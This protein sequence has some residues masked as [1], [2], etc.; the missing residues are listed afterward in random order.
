MLKR[1]S[2]LT[3]PLSSL[4]NYI[5]SIGRNHSN[6]VVVMSFLIGATYL[7]VMVALDR[8]SLQ[9]DISSLTSSQ[10]IRFQQ[11]AN[12]TRALMRASTDPNLPEYIIAPMVD[13][14]REAVT[15][16]RT[17]SEQL[18][19]LH[20][21]IGQNLLEKLTPRDGTSELLRV[22][23]NRR[24]EDFLRRAGRVT[25]AK[26]EERRQR[27]SFWGPIDFAVSSEGTLTRQFSDLIH[28]T[29]DRSN[30][31]IDNAKMIST[32]LLALIAATLA[33]A[34]AFLFSPLLKKLRNEHRRTVD[35]ENQLKQL[36]HTDALTGIHNRSAFSDT[37][38]NLFSELRRNGTGFSVLLLDLDRFKSINDGFGHP[39]GDAVL[40]HVA[41]ALQR[42]F[43]S[44]DFVARLGG[45]EFAVLLPGIYDEATLAGIANRAVE[46]IAADFLFEGRTL[47]VSA[48]IGGAVVPN[49]ATDEP[50]LMRV[51]DLALYTA[52]SGRNT[53]I[54]FD[55]AALARRLEENQLSLALIVA[56]DRNEFIVHYQPK[57]NLVTGEHLGFEALVRWRHPS[58]GIL[59]PGRFL[60]LMEGPH[61]I[62]G[63]TR[64]VATIVG[65][66]LRAWQD[67][68]LI[69]GP[70]A[71]NLP[72]ALLVGEDGYQMLAEV[73]RQNGLD[74][75]DFAV[76]VTEDV[77][78]N[79]N[80]DRILETVTRFREQGLSVSLDD[81]GTGFA[82]LVHLRDFPFDEL[83]IDRSF[84]ADIGTD[85]RSEQIVRAMID[86]SRNLGKRC[87]AEGIETDA[88]RRFLVNAG[89][90]IGQGY[91][92]AKPQPAEVA[93]ERLPKRLLAAE[94]AMSAA[95]RHIRRTAG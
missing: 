89:C 38:G 8:H 86:L 49:H 48:S 17:M 3:K 44:D 63:M 19:D 75:H 71:I 34:S 27:Y 36:A 69:P 16:I 10:F 9:Q 64:S 39:A 43:R 58:L 82:S 12:Q 35:F 73:I 57:V 30:I 70:I 62:R 95:A 4:E 51:A 24:L 14:I 1:S 66:D 67:A 78:L 40:R 20:R 33:L 68:G 59:A 65:R 26:N 72:E 29:H 2:P 53:A 55:E 54:I 90:E 42:V 91:F 85:T 61:L 21:R 46:T 11:L 18:E 92:F 31:S 50:G 87:V 25:A 7:T 84:I 56:V 93:S 94:P 15:D 37:L 47:R 5:K 13:D 88:Q 77:F 28:H 52:K 79:R 6:A 23:L 22:D 74:W 80:A 45:D 60:P 76:E 32:S 83:K 81:F 41:S